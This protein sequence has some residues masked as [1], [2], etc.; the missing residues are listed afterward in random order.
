VNGI[1]GGLWLSI[2]CVLFAVASVVA[3]GSETRVTGHQL[4]SLVRQHFEATERED[5]AALMDMFHP[6]SPFL[7]TTKNAASRLFGSY[8]VKLVLRRFRFFG[9]DDDYAVARVVQVTSDRTN[10]DF[11]DNV[12][13]SMYVFR[14]YRGTWRLWQQIVLEAEILEKSQQ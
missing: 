10:S 2:L 9:N 7:E 12:I 14:R 8:D 4:E 11:Q 3:V 1:R 13:D 5:I 6:E